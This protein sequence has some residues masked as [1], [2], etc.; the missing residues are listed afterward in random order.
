MGTEYED[1]T[2]CRF[3]TSKELRKAK[4]EHEER[5]KL[6][7]AAEVPIPS[8]WAR[9]IA[10]SGSGGSGGQIRF[11][12]P[13]E[14]IDDPGSFERWLR[15][16]AKTFDEEAAREHEQPSPRGNSLILAMRRDVVATNAD[17][18]LSHAF[19]LDHLIPRLN[20]I[21]F[22]SSAEGAA[23]YLRSVLKVV[24]KRLMKAANSRQAQKSQ[25]QQNGSLES[26]NVELLAKWILKTLGNL[27]KN[28]T[29]NGSLSSWKVA[30]SNSGVGDPT[31]RKRALET[32]LDRKLGRM[33]EEWPAL[34]R[35]YSVEEAINEVKN[36]LHRLKSGES[37]TNSQTSKQ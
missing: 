22:N 26:S 24:R 11:N 16:H 7:R 21:E 37:Q 12:A 31:T 17:L 14:Q 25:D 8:W 34:F 3:V 23:V 4:E 28:R 30:G 15:W 10:A 2:V 36:A 20:G 33:N 19:G 5:M 9:N 35:G 29:I 18:M 32:I 27:P 1:G 6:R 13:P